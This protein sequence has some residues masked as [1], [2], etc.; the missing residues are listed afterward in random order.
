MTPRQMTI[1]QTARNRTAFFSKK[2]DP[3][4][5]NWRNLLRS[6]A[7][8]TSTKDLSNTGFEDIMAHLEGF[9]FVDQVHGKDHWQNKVKLRGT[10][11]GE[12]MAY[13]ITERIQSTPYAN[14]LGGLCQRFSG[15]RTDQ[16]TKLRPSE[17]YGL[18]EMLKDVIKRQGK[19]HDPF[20]ITQSSLQPPAPPFFPGLA[21]NPPKRARPVPTPIIDSHGG[22]DEDIP[23]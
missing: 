10:F 8:V 14:G 13:T 16:V 4:E 18:L 12:R 3:A 23:F 21:P 20:P 7:G 22:D 6:V 5:A 2:L 1:L 17:A 11:C 19:A 15:G 9:G